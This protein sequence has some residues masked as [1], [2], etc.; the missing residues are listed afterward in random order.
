MNKLKEAL[1]ALIKKHALKIGKVQLASGASSDFYVDMKNILLLPQGINILSK[2][3]LAFLENKTVIGVGGTSLGAMPIS[4]GVSLM[5]LKKFDHPFK[6]FF[7]Q[8]RVKESWNEKVGR[9]NRQL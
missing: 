1:V 3:I 7:Y 4:V 2:M 6:G 8:K 5:S 9:R